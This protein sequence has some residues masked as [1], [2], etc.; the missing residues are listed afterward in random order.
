MSKKILFTGLIF[1]SFFTSFCQII[2]SQRK[3]NL[4]I[5]KFYKTSFS[6]NAPLDSVSI[7]IHSISMIDARPDSSAIGLIQIFKLDPRFIVTQ[8]NF[9]TES[10]QFVNR[11]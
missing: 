7:A 6:L 9:Q 1:L 3:E 11:Y 2:S 4:N 10:E 8:R 5:N